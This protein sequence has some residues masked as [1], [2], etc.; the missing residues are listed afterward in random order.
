MEDSI[1]ERKLTEPKVNL[2]AATGCRFIRFDTIEEFKF[3]ACIG[4]A[5]RDEEKARAKERIFLFVMHWPMG[6]K[7]Q[8]P[9]LW[10]IYNGRIHKGENDEGIPHHQQLDRTG[11]VELY[12]KKYPQVS[13]YF[14]HYRDVI[15]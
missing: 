11:C 15:A 8:R 5:R 7:L 4:G 12:P 13:I 3:D 1:H 14:A 2:P 9:E 10:N 6:T